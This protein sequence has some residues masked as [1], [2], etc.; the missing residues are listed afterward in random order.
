MFRHDQAEDTV[1]VCHYFSFFYFSF[2]SNLCGNCPD[3]PMLSS[4][5][6][7]N[8]VLSVTHTLSGLAPMNAWKTGIRNS[9]CSGSSGG[10]CRRTEDRCVRKT[11]RKRIFLRSQIVPPFFLCSADYF[12]NITYSYHFLKIKFFNCLIIYEKPSCFFTHFFKKV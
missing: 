10:T 12:Y 11:G 3:P 6:A 1:S 4:E 7:V 8:F 9:F 2:F 5:K